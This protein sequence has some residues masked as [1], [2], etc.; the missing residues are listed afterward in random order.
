MRESARTFRRPVPK[1]EHGDKKQGRPYRT[2]APDRNGRIRP[3]RSAT[4]GRAAGSRSKKHS[5][6]G[7]NRNPENETG[8]QASAAHDRGRRL[9][10][11]SHRRS[12]PRR[13][14][15]TARFCGHGLRTEIVPR[16]PRSSRPPSGETRQPGFSPASRNL[17]PRKRG[18][19]EPPEA[20]PEDALS[21]RIF[22]PGKSFPRPP[23][24]NHPSAAAFFPN[25]RLIHRGKI[26][27]PMAK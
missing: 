12:G 10:L 6:S 11:S 27:A 21:A 26:T 19:E 23:R 4:I 25:F 24:K 5:G 13:K 3:Q 7:Q 2:G 14:S 15:P 20:R 16:S 1:K 22:R 8:R 17:Y 9:S 18:S